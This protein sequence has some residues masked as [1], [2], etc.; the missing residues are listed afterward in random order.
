MTAHD[1]L[2]PRPAGLAGHVRRANALGDL[3]PGDVVALAAR[4][5]PAVVFWQSGRT[6][7]EGLTIKDSTWF[8]FQDLY[9]L[10]LIPPAWAAVMATV[11]EHVLPVLLVLGLLSRLSAAGL[12]AMTAVIQIFVRAPTRASQGR[13]EVVPLDFSHNAWLVVAS[14]AIALMAG[15]TGLSMARGLSRVPPGER[16]LRVAMS[17][18]VLGGG[19]WSMH[20]VAML[21]LQLPIPFYYDPLVTLISALLGIL[22]VGLGLILL[23][24]RRRTPATITGA[25]LI[26]GIGILGMHYTGMAGMQACRA[27]YTPGGI[28]LSVTTSLALA[29]LAVW[30]A[31]GERTR[32][33]VLLGTLC[34]ATAVVA[35]HYIAI[36]NTRFL[37]APLAEF[38]LMIGNEALAMVVTLAAFVICG[39]FLLAG[40]TFFPDAAEAEAL[41]AAA[42]PP[43][44][45]PDPGPGTGDAGRSFR[46]IP[47]EREGRTLFAEPAS[48]AAFRAEGH[49]TILY[50]GA[51][52]VFCPWSI[53]EAEK[54][55]D[56]TAFVR[57]HRSYLVNPAHV[58]GFE[59]RK[60]TGVIYFDG[61][62]ALGKVPVARSRLTEVRDLLGL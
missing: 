56:G 5:F 59:R 49:Y 62:A 22:V 7:V 28:A 60:D 4:V 45:A 26:V 16:K 6:K 40:A 15:F 21:G 39:A 47:Y 18:V 57:V 54:R 19:I 51:E 36:W 37:E 8:L 30:I 29:T 1:T 34:F 20:F 41:P 31:Y 23:H 10:P 14:F 61:V 32:R 46:Q 11:A 2:A 48:I 44:P 25:G 52:K 24:F 12:L 38:D 53:S 35:L 50:R 42:P 9:A 13:G 55:L 43:P 27:E 33:N 17:A 58:T 3:I